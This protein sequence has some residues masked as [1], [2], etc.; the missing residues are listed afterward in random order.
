MK[1]ARTILSENLKA[2]M[3]THPGLDTCKAIAK[4]GGPSNGTVERILNSKVGASIDQLDLL[5]N[6][7]ELEPW[8]L[9]VPGL[10]PT[11]PPILAHISA[12][13]LE[14]LSKIKRLPKPE[15]NHH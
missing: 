7:Y 3:A 9:L 6:I 11:N 15:K 5:A 14:M 12:Q 13:Q 2:L 10:D 1:T 4:A 8:Q